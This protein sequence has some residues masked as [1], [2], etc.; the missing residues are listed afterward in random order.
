MLGISQAQEAI[1][2]G[3]TSDQEITMNKLSEG[4]QPL[5]SDVAAV[6][7][8]LEHNGRIGRLK[9][10][11]YPENIS[12]ED[13]AKSLTLESLKEKTKLF[14]D[15][16]TDRDFVS[17]SSLT[18]VSD[19]NLFQENSRWWSMINHSDSNIHVA[20]PQFD[21]STNAIIP[22]LSNSVNDVINNNIASNTIINN[23]DNTM[24]APST[25]TSD[26]TNNNNSNKK[27]NSISNNVNNHDSMSTNFHRNRQ[28]RRRSSLLS[29]I[30]FESDDNNEDDQTTESGDSSWG[31]SS[32][33]LTTARRFAPNYTSSGS[34]GCGVNNDIIEEE[35][36]DY[37]EK[38][39]YRDVSTAAPV[40][41]RRRISKNY[42]GTNRA[43]LNSNSSSLK[44]AAAK[45]TSGTNEFEISP[46]KRS[47]CNPAYALRAMARGNASSAAPTI[48]KRTSSHNSKKPAVKN[49]PILYQIYNASMTSIVS[50][51]ISQDTEPSFFEDGSAAAAA[52]AAYLSTDAK[53]SQQEEAR[54]VQTALTS[55][56]S[57]TTE[58]S[59][60][61]NLKPDDRRLPR[62]EVPIES[63]TPP[64]LPERQNSDNQLP[65]VFGT[66]SSFDEDS[67]EHPSVVHEEEP[68]DSDSAI[69][70]SRRSHH[71]LPSVPRRKHSGSDKNSSYSSRSSGQRKP[72]PRL[73]VTHQAPT[74]PMR[75]DS[76]HSHAHAHAQKSPIPMHSPVIHS[77]RNAAF[78]RMR[79]SP[80]KPSGQQTMLS[81]KHRPPTKPTRTSSS[82]KNR[83]AAHASN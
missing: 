30:T 4:N 76:N 47:H 43:S 55:L 14:F 15:S 50:S 18:I 53:S 23:N 38:L 20:N 82:T 8:V 21:S 10:G 67:D 35:H 73:N 1:D 6:A 61:K 25:N 83:V 65:P 27:N 31:H 3:D 13:D 37:H 60:L 56:T 41:P 39:K 16:H 7:F 75:K 45:V 74:I 22:N 46:S 72:A 77:N 44:S 26:N 48:P 71:Q 17:Q 54:T 11:D 32:A 79:L 29:D 19:S 51:Q 2:G 70:T 42:H 5:L 28:T 78:N 66:F 68:Q 81:Q 63:E 58:T 57:H 49:N 59:V 69:S 34:C 80:H 9:D 40:I 64:T 62:Q 33:L 36:H 24:N 12:E 52:A